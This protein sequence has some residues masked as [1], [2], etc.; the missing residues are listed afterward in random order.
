M[1]GYWGEDLLNFHPSM[2]GYGLVVQ[3]P[4]REIPP[5]LGER[6]EICISLY[7]IC[8]TCR[9]FFGFGKVS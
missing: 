2:A 1:R 9:R 7:A 4:M 3:M 5:G 6:S 8:F